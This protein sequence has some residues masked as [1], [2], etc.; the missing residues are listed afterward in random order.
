ME[1]PERHTPQ[2]SKR[3]EA[4]LNLASYFSR[5]FEQNGIA[6]LEEELVTEKL[7]VDTYKIVKKAEGFEV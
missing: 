7:A 2:V 6:F 5:F 1:G 3:G 4:L